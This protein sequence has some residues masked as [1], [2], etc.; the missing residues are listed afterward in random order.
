MLPSDADVAACKM[1]GEPGGSDYDDVHVGH[2]AQAQHAAAAAM[3]PSTWRPAGGSSEEAPGALV[4]I[5]LPVHNGSSWIDGCLDALRVQTLLQPNH[6]HWHT[7]LSETEREAAALVEL[8]AFDDGSTDD[9]WERL[10]SWAPRLAQCGWRVVLSRSGSEIGS[11][12]GNAKN[13]AVAQSTGAWLCF[14]DVDD[15]SDP[16]RLAV[17]LAAAR[18]RG[19]CI[20]G[21]RVVR[22]PAGSTERYVSWANGMSSEQLITHRFREC[23]LLMPTWFMSRSTFDAGL[24]FRE[25]RCEDLLFLLGHVARGG[26]LHRCDETLVEYRYHAAAATHAIPRQTIMRHRAA[27]IERAILSQWPTFTIWGAGRDGRDFYKALTPGTRRRVRAF[28][29]V[30]AKKVG[31]TYQYFDETVPIVHFR[32]ASPPFVTCVALDRTG[33]AFE[34]NLASLGLEEGDGYYLFG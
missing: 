18:D 20:L 30:D 9:S 28:C 29:D 23:T 1:V 19:D 3:P 17:Q 32:D 13:R 8:S 4:S 6:P 33:G 12:C 10:L 2:F 22:T 34:A 5:I 21:A 11:G 7:V 31:T 16:S 25:E 14:H 26:K 27:A 24:G 15:V